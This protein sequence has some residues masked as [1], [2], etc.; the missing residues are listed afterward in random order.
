MSICE[1]KIFE[2]KVTPI[3]QSVGYRAQGH[4]VAVM[5]C[6]VIFYSVMISYIF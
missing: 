5:G 3:N 1:G 6:L 4:L 2:I